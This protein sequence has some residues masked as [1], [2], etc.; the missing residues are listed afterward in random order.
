MAGQL[1]AEW[2]LQIS[3][4][5]S[6]RPAGNENS[7]IPTGAIEVMG[8]DVVVLSESAPLPFP[9]DSGSEVDISE[10]VRLRYRYLD[11]RREGPASN[12]R[13]RSKVTSAI[14]NVMELSLIHI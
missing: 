3:G 11:L 13:M 9:V 7:N 12:L 8:D 4:E 2:C 14:R 6:L 5:V 1:R 10:E